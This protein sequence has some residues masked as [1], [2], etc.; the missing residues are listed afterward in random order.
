[1]AS[2]SGPALRRQ[3]GLWSAVAIVIGQIIG[4]GIFRSPAGITDKLPGPFPLLVVW[5]AGGV[6]AL[7]GALSLAEVAADK[8]ALLDRIRQVNGQSD[9]DGKMTPE[10]QQAK[11]QQAA[12]AKQKFDAEMGKLTSEIKRTTSQ[13]AKFDA[14]TML[15]K[16][17]ALYEEPKLPPCW[18][19]LRP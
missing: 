4:S 14:D 3:I 16:V 5:T 17:T 19:N 2:A 9:P 8:K 1:M 13:G 12:I 15:V 7:C 11:A 6:F 10:Q 18:A